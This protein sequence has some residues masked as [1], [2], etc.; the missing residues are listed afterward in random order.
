MQKWH[1]DEYHRDAAGRDIIVG[2]IIVYAS[3]SGR[4]PVLKW[5]VIVA[6]KSRDEYRYDATGGVQRNMSIKQ[7]TVGV[8]SVGGSNKQSTLGFLNRMSIISIDQVPTICRD[9]IR[10]FI[11]AL[12]G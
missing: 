10:D 1:P 11:D 3:L 7:A 6:L 2:D 9:T 12:N 5:G 4:S 8:R